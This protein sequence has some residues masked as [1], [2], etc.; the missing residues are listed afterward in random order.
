MP[1]EQL[2]IQPVR[3]AG[4]ERHDDRDR[5]ALVEIRHRVGAGGRGRGHGGEN[6]RGADGAHGGPEARGGG[7]GNAGLPPGDSEEAVG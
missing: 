5:P 4:A 6:Q 2:R 7:G 1:G 3:A